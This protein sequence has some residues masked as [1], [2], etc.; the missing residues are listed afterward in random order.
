MCKHV[1]HMLNKIENV[2]KQSLFCALIRYFSFLP[3]VVFCCSQQHTFNVSYFQPEPSEFVR[4]CRC[5]KPASRVTARVDTAPAP[6]LTS[7]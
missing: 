6:D 3:D 5:R 1:K 7:V 2:L 4:L